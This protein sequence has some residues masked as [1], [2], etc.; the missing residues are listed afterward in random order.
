MVAQ[1]K[2]ENKEK[3]RILVRKTENCSLRKM[4]RSSVPPVGWGMELKLLLPCKF[5]RELPMPLG[6]L[7][8]HC[9]CH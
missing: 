8:L 3:F 2:G 7:Q 1:K 5:F 6:T 9:S 4:Q